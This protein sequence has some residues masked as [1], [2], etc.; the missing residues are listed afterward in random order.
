MTAVKEL[1]VVKDVT[2][3]FCGVTCD[4]LEVHVDNGKIVDVKNA[5]VL[6]KDTFLHHLEGLATPRIDGKPAFASTA[7]SEYQPYGCSRHTRRF[8][9]RPPELWAKCG[10]TVTASTSSGPHSRVG[11]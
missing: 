5:C 1:T 11:P 8:F 6:G 4:D 2:C 10:R 9:R 3:I 7:P